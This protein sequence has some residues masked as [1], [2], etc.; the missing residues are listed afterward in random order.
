LMALLP[1]RSQGTGMSWLSHYGTHGLQLRPMMHQQVALGLG[2]P[3]LPTSPAS[4]Q[5]SRQPKSRLLPWA[6]VLVGRGL[7]GLHPRDYMWA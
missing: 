6:T 7:P 1:T 3:L 4:A 2:V 5:T